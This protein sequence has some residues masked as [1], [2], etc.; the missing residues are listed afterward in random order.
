MAPV[1]SPNDQAAIGASAM[2][3]YVS[4]RYKETK[5]QHRARESRVATVFDTRACGAMR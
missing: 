4:S 5:L 1:L 2:L 3:G